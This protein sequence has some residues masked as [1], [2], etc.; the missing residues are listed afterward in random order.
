MRWDSVADARAQFVDAGLTTVNQVWLNTVFE[1]DRRTAP[2]R[3]RIAGR[4]PR[5][6]ALTWQRPATD[7]ASS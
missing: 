6:F 1:V 2:L 3:W 7:Q 4:L 5:F